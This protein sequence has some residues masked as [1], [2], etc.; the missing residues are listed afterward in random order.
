MNE[1]YFHTLPRTSGLHPLGNHGCTLLEFTKINL[2]A[3][4]HLAGQISASR[5]ALLVMLS[6]KA[7]ITVN[8]QSFEIGGRPNVFAGLPHSLYLPR[9][10]TYTIHALSKLE[11]AL[12]S[13]PSSL[14]TDAYEIKPDQVRTGQ[15]GTLNYTRQY[16]EILVAPNG[17]PASSLIVGE[18]ITPSGNW[19][20]YPPHKHEL[21]DAGEV[22]H[23]EM[24]YF[25]VSSPEG[26]GLTRHY[27]AERGYDHTYAVKDDTIL[28]IP[29]GYHTYSS[30]PGYASYYL[31]F[32]A[33]DGRTQGVKLDPD[34][35]W[36]QKTVGMV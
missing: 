25:R 23:E 33:G 12:P 20:T 10:C 35:G 14:D 29:H 5:E 2:A 18:T 16:R 17:L 13:A 26:W 34:V 11:A 1:R 21:N 15:W 19:S 27:S 7:R 24:Y 31:W 30:A 8:G 4:E 32:L 22:F 9:G 36:V 6:G 28:S 3:N